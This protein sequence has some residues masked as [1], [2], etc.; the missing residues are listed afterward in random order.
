MAAPN[1]P[2]TPSAKQS[3]CFLLQR[4]SK[5]YQRA[6]IEVEKRGLNPDAIPTAHTI[7]RVSPSSQNGPDFFIGI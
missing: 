7:W 6:R 5:D 3:F 1:E 2:F 4:R